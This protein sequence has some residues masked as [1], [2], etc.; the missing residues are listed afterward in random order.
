MAEVSIEYCEKGRSGKAYQTIRKQG[1]LWNIHSRKKFGKGF[2]A[3]I[4][5]AEVENYLTDL[6]HKKKYS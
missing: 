3:G 2:I 1:S 4:S 6:Y 5:V